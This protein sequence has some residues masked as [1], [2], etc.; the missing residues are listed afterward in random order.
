MFACRETNTN[1]AYKPSLKSVYGADTNI[2]CLQID[3][4]DSMGDLMG[5]HHA[6]HHWLRYQ[7]H[8]SI[9]VCRYFCTIVSTV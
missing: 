7:K 3:Q 5:Q 9:P 8:Q 6:D 4:V 2:A 1:E